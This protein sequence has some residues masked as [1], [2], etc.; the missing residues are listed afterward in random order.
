[1]VTIFDRKVPFG[2]THGLK[3][4]VDGEEAYRCATA[5]M[6]EGYTPVPSDDL[7]V[8]LLSNLH[9]GHE[10]GFR[11]PDEDMTHIIAFVMVFMAEFTSGEEPDSSLSREVNAIV[12]RS[13]P[14]D[15]RS[16]PPGFMTLCVK[17]TAQRLAVRTILKLAGCSEDVVGLTVDYSLQEALDV[18]RTANATGFSTAYEIRS[19]ALRTR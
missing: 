2:K 10:V 9:D 12:G 18:V 16:M 1:M 11:G 14:E 6:S 17:A 8:F 5:L 15:L 19:R 4:Q 7:S 13:L 3:K